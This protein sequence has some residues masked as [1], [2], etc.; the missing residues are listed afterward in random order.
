V[1][2]ESDT[3]GSSARTAQRKMNFR[4]QT[5][6]RDKDS[7]SDDVDVGVGIGVDVTGGNWDSGGGDCDGALAWFTC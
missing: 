7:S 4:L 2:D 5:A 1:L 3:G 6:V